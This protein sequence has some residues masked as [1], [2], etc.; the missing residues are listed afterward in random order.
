MAREAGVVA[1]QCAMLAVMI[2][3]DKEEFE[4]LSR[5]QIFSLQN[6]TFLNL[7]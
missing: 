5:Q 7:N 2:E 6:Q 4:Y 1:R 3:E